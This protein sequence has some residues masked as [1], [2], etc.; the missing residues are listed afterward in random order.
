MIS[1]IIKVSASVIS[2]DLRPAPNEPDMLPKRTKKVR[3]GIYHTQIQPKISANSLCSS[4]VCQVRSA[5]CVG[6]LVLILFW[7]ST[8]LSSSSSDIFLTRLFGVSFSKFPKSKFSEKFG[9]SDSIVSVLSTCRRSWRASYCLVLAGTFFCA[10]FRTQNTSFIL[11]TSCLFI[12]K[13]S[14]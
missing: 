2:L 3:L 12:G 9:N 10:F 7:S 14:L 5:N 13:T 4:H 6:L 1:R 11:I 8:L